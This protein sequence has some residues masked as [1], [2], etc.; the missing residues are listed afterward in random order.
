MI[1]F[2]KNEYK[3][4]RSIAIKGNT[5]IEVTSRFIKEKMLMLSKVSIRSIMYYLIDVF[6]FPDETVKEIYCQ[7]SIIKFNLYLNLIDN[8]PCS[9][10]FIKKNV[11]NPEKLFNISKILIFEIVKQSKIVK[12]FFFHLLI[13]F[14]NTNISLQIQVIILN[15]NMFAGGL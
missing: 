10:L 12:R 15:K 11:R 8:N 7:N 5:A 1:D 6:C 9:I 13:Y 14:T 4:I 3:S 2:D